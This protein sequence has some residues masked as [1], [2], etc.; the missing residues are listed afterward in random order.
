MDWIKDHWKSL[1]GATLSL[2]MTT[3]LVYYC[4]QMD[5]ED[6]NQRKKLCRKGKTKFHNEIG[7]K[8]SQAEKEVKGR[9]W[10]EKY[11]RE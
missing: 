6:E 7:I 9:A 4:A 11:V 5:F 8:L 1:T 3:Y 2:A 10:L